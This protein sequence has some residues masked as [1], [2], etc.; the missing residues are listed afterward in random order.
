[1]HWGS[2]L[3]AAHTPY[4]PLAAFPGAGGA[5]P[6]WAGQI[7]AGLQALQGQVQAVQGQVQA[8][9]EHQDELQDQLTE[10]QLT[11]ERL[12]NRTSLDVS[13]AREANQTAMYDHSALTPVPNLDTGAAPPPGFPATRGGELSAAAAHF[14]CVVFGLRRTAVGQVILMRN[15]S[16]PSQHPHCPTN[17]HAA[18]PAEL[19][20]LLAPD[21]N[22]L[23]AFYGGAQVGGGAAARLTHLAALLG[24]RI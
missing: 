4:A 3:A 9:L 10:V 17:A 7:A 20:G 2:F 13:L 22:A 24:V 19:K 5:A 23:L 1:M 6:P 18:L 21:V 12:I 14:L 15:V 16:A 11:V 8:V